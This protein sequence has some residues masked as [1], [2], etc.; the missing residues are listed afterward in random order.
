MN[1]KN[2][3]IYRDTLFEYEHWSAEELRWEL[4]HILV[5]IL[6]ETDKNE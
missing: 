5:A 4:F 3:E 1:R 2:L 6:E